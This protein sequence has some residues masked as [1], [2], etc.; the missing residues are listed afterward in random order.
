MHAMSLGEKQ[1][2]RD[3]TIQS[4][5]GDRLFRD[6]FRVFG[7]VRLWLTALPRRVE[8][9]R[10]R[11]EFSLKVTIVAHEIAVSMPQSVK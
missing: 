10:L 3:A 4:C 1:L 7:G 2:K 6:G 11:I 9:R 5:S 8:G